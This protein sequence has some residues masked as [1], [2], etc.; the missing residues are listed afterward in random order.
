MKIYKVNII[1]HNEAQIEVEAE[2]EDKAE[3]KAR[4]MY[5]KGE[6]MMDEYWRDNG[7]VDF[8]VDHSEPTKIY[9]KE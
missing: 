3:E 4:E 5:D 1:E 9:I 2:N 7:Y 8:L 6:I